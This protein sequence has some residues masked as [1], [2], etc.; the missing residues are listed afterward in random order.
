M[1]IAT[2]SAL[3]S[4]FLRRTRNGPLALATLQ[5]LVAISS[6]LSLLALV[7]LDPVVAASWMGGNDN[8]SVRA[9]RIPAAVALFPP[10]LF[11]GMSFPLAVTLYTAGAATQPSESR[12]PLG[13]RLG[14][15]YAA[16]VGGAIVGALAAGFLLVPVLGT[17]NTLLL[18]AGLNWATA[19][20]I[21]LADGLSPIRTRLTI[22]AASL[23]IVG[24]LAA[25]TP[26][27]YQS[28][29]RAR[30]PG[31]TVLWS[32]EGLETT[33]TVTDDGEQLSMYLNRAHQANDAN[34]MVFFHRMIGHVPM[35]VHPDPR[36][37]LVVGLGGGAT[38]GATTRY[39][40]ARVTVV[41]LSRSVVHGAEWF[42]DVNYAVVEQPNVR[43]L[44]DDGRN[45]LMVSGRRY[46]VITADTIW[47]THAGSNNLY[48]AE[49]YRV[50]RAALN[51]GGVMLQWVER[52]LPEA[53]HKLLMRTFLQAFPH[54][55]LWFDG[56]L[57]VGSNE[58][59]DPRSGLERKFAW[60]LSQAALRQ[61][62]LRSPDDVLGLYVTDRAGIQAYVGEGPIITDDHPYLEYFLG[63][64]SDSGP[65]ARRVR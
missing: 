20:L 11:L 8:L 17:R 50:A 57:M 49:Y 13:R 39:E 46:D 4:P 32:E 65:G 60:P 16:N 24:I 53:Q 43:V 15:L 9:M 42:R 31:E 40:N 3:V 51:D 48:S 45:H 22:A 29:F 59:I 63:L 44:I 26:V 25:L 18:L 7:A 28:V 2:G 14:S 34:W 10:A 37:V 61:V 52:S 36:E 55:T 27:A 33:V 30:F 23:A 35:L 5:A 1:G 12:A 56:T 38:A 6:L 47:P 19:A 54:V 41:E 21:L 64:P 62:D 58:P